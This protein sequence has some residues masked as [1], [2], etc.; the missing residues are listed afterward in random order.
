MKLDLP[1]SKDRAIRSSKKTIGI[2][3]TYPRLTETSEPRRDRLFC[4][5]ARFAVWLV[6]YART[7]IA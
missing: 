2:S 6:G 3:S 1:I 5:A 4:P 7:V